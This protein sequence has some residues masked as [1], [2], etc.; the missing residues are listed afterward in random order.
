MCFPSMA[1]V[2]MFTHE[3]PYTQKVHISKNFII[4]SV[5][6]VCNYE[7]QVAKIF[8][9]EFSVKYRPKTTTIIY[10]IYAWH[11]G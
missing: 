5:F 11:H 4:F 6:Y 1:P 8:V 7:V 10:E 2:K 9:E 3:I